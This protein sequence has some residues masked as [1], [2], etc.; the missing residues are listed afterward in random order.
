MSPKGA[1]DPTRESEY[2]AEGAVPIETT[3]GDT[4]SPLLHFHRPLKGVF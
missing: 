4:K 2:A 3:V 1:P